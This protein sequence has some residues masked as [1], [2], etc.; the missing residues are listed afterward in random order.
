MSNLCIL[1]H[2]EKLC[3]TNEWG[4]LRALNKTKYTCVFA[5]KNAK[6]N[7]KILKLYVK[8]LITYI[9]EFFKRYKNNFINWFIIHKY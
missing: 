1:I 2:L 5:W 8:Y 3:Y 7:L 4:G 6:Y 9:K